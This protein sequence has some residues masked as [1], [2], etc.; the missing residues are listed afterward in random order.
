MTSKQ[1]IEIEFIDGSS[2]L[3]IFFGGIQ[4]G[5]VMPSFEFY[6]SSKIISENKIFV[7]DFDQCWYQKG[8]PGAGND[9]PAIA[10]YLKLM[11]NEVGA[12]K[13]FFVGN[14]MGGFAAILFVALIGLG[15][16]IAFAP[17]T[18][19]SRDLRLRHDDSRWLSQ[20]DNMYNLPIIKEEYLDLRRLLLG[21]KNKPKLSI[22][23]STNDSLDEAHANHLQDVPN[24]RVFKFK[25]GGH[26]VVKLLR[27][28][29]KLPEILS[30]EYP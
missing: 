8:L 9:V 18:F 21:L 22:F 13:V 6:N 5:I 2:K 17:Q 12:E 26:G 16:A 15:E 19:V 25:E 20:I 4:A 30:G 23:V 24:V 7:R 11:I 3:Y 29:G 27:D 1:A 28:L 10:A 14:S